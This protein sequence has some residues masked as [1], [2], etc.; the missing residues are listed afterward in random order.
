MARYKMVKAPIL[1]KLLNEADKLFHSQ[2]REINSLKGQLELMIKERNNFKKKYHELSSIKRDY[3]LMKK[4]KN[5]LVI[6]YAKKL[7]VLK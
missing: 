5:K 4:E 6:A 3:E 2:S 1:R 7:G